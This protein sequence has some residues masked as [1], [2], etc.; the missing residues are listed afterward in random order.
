MKMQRIA[1]QGKAS[2]RKWGDTQAKG[3]D[4]LIISNTPLKGF[5]DQ[6]GDIHPGV[7]MGGWRRVT[8]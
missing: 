4:C 6:R 8:G 5:M 7:H 3:K 1:W 2:I